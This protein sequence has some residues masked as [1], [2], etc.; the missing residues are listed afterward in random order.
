MH[1]KIKIKCPDSIK[2]HIAKVLRGEY[3]IPLKFPTDKP[4]VLDIGANV[5]SFAIWAYKVWP[6]CTVHC[7]EPSKDNFKL[8]EQNI[9]Q[10]DSKDIHLNNVAVGDV[11]RTRLY[12]G[13]NNCGEKSLHHLGEQSEDFEVVK[14]IDPLSLPKADI[15]KMDT[16]GSEFDI[17]E[18]IVDIDYKAIMFEYHWETDRRTLDSMLENYCLVGGHVRCLNRGVMKYIRKDLT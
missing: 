8:L 14:T 1:G 11:L 17:L 7:Y 12:D 5:G 18:R 10:L 4:V 3:A 6:G 9:S 15:L 16:E 13:L 2:P